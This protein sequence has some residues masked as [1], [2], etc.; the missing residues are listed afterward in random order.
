MSFHDAADYI[1]VGS[2]AAGATA[3]LELARA[4]RDVVLLEEGRRVDPREYDPSLWTTAQNFFRDGGSSFMRGP[5]LIP[6][7][8]GRCVGG[9]TV[10]NSAICWRLPESIHAEWVRA[11]RAIGEAL[12]FATIDAVA[13]ELEAELRIRPTPQEVLGGNNSRLQA[14]A[15]A[16][17]YR[18]HPIVR[19]VVGCEGS[20]MCLQGCRNGHKQSMDVSF[21]PRFTAA[22]GRLLAEHRA[23]RVLHERGRALGVEIVTGTPPRRLRI[24][25]RRGVLLAASALQSPVLLM[26]SGLGKAGPVG[27]FFACHPGASIASLYDTPV[28]MWKGATQGYEVDETLGRG[29][30]L[31]T[32]SLPPELLALRLPGV[33]SKLGGLLARGRHVALWGA[34]IR[35]PSRGKVVARGGK[36]V[37]H[38]KLGPTD[39]AMFRDGLLRCVEI[40]FAAGATVCLPGLWGLPERVH[41]VE[42]FARALPQFTDPR[43]VSCIANHLFGTARMGTDPKQS[44]VSPRFEHHGVRG[45]FVIDSSVFPSNT[46]V[47][48][49]LS[50]MSLAR[51]AARGMIESP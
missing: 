32:L 15:E 7:L 14:G 1:V 9:S 38:F 33:G 17:G 27:Q 47:N 48:P 19:N 11:D 2:G 13:A 51:L 35:S 36:A 5:S 23:T 31:E 24:E 34:E 49:Q 29:I 16:L 45:L 12:P 50:I 26:E 44:V 43:Q 3:A 25:A 40:A 41:S 6:V 22:G 42:E 10:I 30:K 37:V 8:Q 18:G 4:G 28:D 21:I 39:T 46:G 20:A